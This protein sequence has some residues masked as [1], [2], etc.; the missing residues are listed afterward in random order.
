MISSADKAFLYAG[1]SGAGHFVKMA[2]NGIEY[3]M[4]Q[5][6]AEGFSVL[7]SSPFALPLADVADLYN[8]RSVIESRLMGWLRNAYQ[9]TAMT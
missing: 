3:G 4:M 2:H 1:S 5:A 7:K 9:S 6:L 8:H